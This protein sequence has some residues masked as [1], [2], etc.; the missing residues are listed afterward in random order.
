MLRSLRI[1]NFALV[2]QL[3]LELGAGLTVLTGETGAGK[4]II[5]DAIDAVL[6]G[7]VTSRLLRTGCDRG[8]VEGT[9]A[10]TEDLRL[11]LQRQEIDLIDEDSIICSREFSATQG[12]LRSRSRINGVL[13]NRQLVSQLRD[14]FVEI[15]AQGQTAQLLIASHQRELL[16]SYGGTALL[17]ARSQVAE[18]FAAYRQA[19]RALD[20]HRQ[21]EKDRLQRL[22]WL[23]YQHQELTEADLDDPDELTQL[24]QERD[25]LSHVVELQQ[26]GY[27]AYQDLYQNEQGGEAIADRL[28]QVQAQVESMTHYDSHLE[29]VLEMVQSALNQVIDAGQLLNRYSDSLESDPERLAE[30]E[31]RLTTLRQI[32]RKYGPDLPD[33]IAHADAIASELHDLTNGDQSLD[34]LEQAHRDCHQIL[35]TGCDHLHSQRDRAAQRLTKQLVRELKPLAMDKVQFDCRLL[36]IEPTA[37]GGDQVVFYF[38]PNPG[39]PLQPLAETA[40]G[41][42]MSRFLLA[43]KAC[44]SGDQTQAGKTLIF[45]EID[46]GVS[47]K[48][49]QAIA[50]KLHHL[51]QS[52]Q[53]LCVTHQPLIAALADAHFRVDKQV[54]KAPKSA[55]RTLVRV[56]RLDH[57]DS[58]KA[59]L[60]QLTGGHSAQDAIA[61]AESLLSQADAKRT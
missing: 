16:D 29:G 25:R 46:A 43:L 20:A 47:G 48:V 14:R 51:S 32:C 1:E 37:H 13:V 56:T 34:Q 50:A 5:L 40:S 42:E 2:D 58:R 35:T 15:T 17:K 12:S 11:W 57:H 28:G 9:F 8:C 54:E 60:A 41:G 4:S 21:S 36:P 26:M 52:H 59:E 3:E 44:F 10:L 49:A 18:A 33:A 61:F 27:Q 30:V 19:Q 39:E 38:S 24:E 22:D 45:D 31:S 6:G 23:R 7:K 53:I 55:P